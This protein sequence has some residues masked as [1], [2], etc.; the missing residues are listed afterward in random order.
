MKR[1]PSTWQR[2]WDAVIGREAEY[3]AAAP[4]CVDVSVAI[5][6]LSCNELLLGP[7]Q[8]QIDPRT[9]LMSMLNLPRHR[10]EAMTAP[11]S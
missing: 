4:R 1:L 8:W 11:V 5:S 3:P 9:A 6:I 7:Q 2:N 10:F